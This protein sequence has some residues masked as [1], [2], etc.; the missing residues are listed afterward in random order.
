MSCC[1][2]KRQAWRVQTTRHLP[3]TDLPAPALQNPTI[4]YYLGNSPIVVRGTYTGIT[5]LFGA[6]GTG[7]TVDARDVPA[8][9]ATGRFA[10]T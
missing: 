2:Q 1:G 3:A 7:L 5:Y 10:R 8:F 9:V 4:L 6:A